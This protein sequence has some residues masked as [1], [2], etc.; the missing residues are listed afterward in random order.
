MDYQGHTKSDGATAHILLEGA[1]PAGAIFADTLT[2]LN[3]ASS[4]PLHLRGIPGALR[5]LK[6]Y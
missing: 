5:L 3:E 1:P 4:N 6:Q 2:G